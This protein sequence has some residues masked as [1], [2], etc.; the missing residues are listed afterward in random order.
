VRQT[1]TNIYA[2]D[3]LSQLRARYRL[4]RIRGLSRTNPHYYRNRQLLVNRLSRRRGE[5]SPV[6]I[7]DID[8]QPYLVLAVKPR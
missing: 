2:I 8:N 3:N 1:I 6:T 5:T 7:I 4:C